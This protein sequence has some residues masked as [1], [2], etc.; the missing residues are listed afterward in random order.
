MA[1][2]AVSHPVTPGGRRQA[3]LVETLSEILEAQRDLTEALAF[4][5]DHDL[6]RRAERLASMIGEFIAPHLPQPGP[7]LADDLTA[8]LDDVRTLRLP[9]SD[10]EFGRTE[11]LRRLRGGTGLVIQALTDALDAAAALGLGPRQVAQPGEPEPQP[12]EP[13]EVPRAGLEQRVAGLE[14]QLGI[15]Q[16]RMDSLRAVASEPIT[17]VNHTAVHQTQVLQFN[18]INNFVAQMRVRVDVVRLALGDIGG[19]INLS[20]LTRGITVMADVTSDFLSTVRDWRQRDQGRVS[21]TVTRLAEGV[22]DR[23]NRVGIRARG[24]VRVVHRRLMRATAQGTESLPP[25]TGRLVAEVPGEALSAQASAQPPAS[26]ITDPIEILNAT[27]AAGLA[28]VFSQEEAERMI[29]AGIAPP[30]AWRPFI[31]Q[32]S[33]GRYDFGETGLIIDRDA[34]PDGDD[35]NKFIDLHLLTDLPNLRHL[36]LDRVDVTNLNPLSRLTALQKLLLSGTKV[37][38]IRPLAMLSGLQSLNLYSHLVIDLAPLARLSS[39]Q[40][41]TV[42]APRVRDFTPLAEL[43][44]LQSL[45]L[46]GSRISDLTPL[47][48]LSALQT[49]NLDFTQISNIAPLAGLTALQSLGLD[50]TQVSDVAPLAGLTALQSL[51]LDNT[52]VS[53][54]APLAGLTRLRRLALKGTR[55][56]DLSPVRGIEGLAIIG[57]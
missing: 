31:T 48:G 24:I 28:P 5:N 20:G 43:A 57:P 32:L 37:R 15:V 50:S 19:L 55:V 16:G 36:A 26:T 4:V 35:I 7:T 56:T 17:Q 47:A 9:A 41:L 34:P 33:F 8:L 42:I 10:G 46:I 44:A 21:D 25:V 12:G 39:L 29:L 40:S 1:Q 22:R 2:P 53:D 38:D 30:H 3:K 51:D 45:T 54:I 11:A 13:V 23:V 49:L 52:Q 14:Y 27:A 6:R 18:L